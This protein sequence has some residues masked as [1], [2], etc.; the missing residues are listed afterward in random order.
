MCRSRCDQQ[1]TIEWRR[2][3]ARAESPRLHGNEASVTMRLGT[4]ACQGVP[5]KDCRTNSHYLC[6]GAMATVIFRR[7][8]TYNISV[9][10]AATDGGDDR[11]LRRQ[12]AG[13]GS[14]RGWGRH[15]LTK[16]VDLPRLLALVGD[17]LAQS[18]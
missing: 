17:A 4:A 9:A 14:P 18:K 15:V 3:V 13:R 8:R 16:P 2:G 7:D 10:V 5:H 6:L 11:R 12:R 1:I